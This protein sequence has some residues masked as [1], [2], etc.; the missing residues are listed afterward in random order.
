[1]RSVITHNYYFIVTRY[2]CVTHAPLSK[3]ELPAKMISSYLK[4]WDMGVGISSLRMDV[5]LVCVLLS[6]L[7]PQPRSTLK[8]ISLQSCANSKSDKHATR[9]LD[10][11]I[12]ATRYV[13][14]KNQYS[15]QY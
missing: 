13:Q 15:D 9:D 5:Y 3:F 1:M 10:F 6:N 4:S 12:I 14:Y 2:S 8:D 7:A 11:V